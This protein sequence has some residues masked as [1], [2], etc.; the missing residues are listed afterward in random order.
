MKQILSY[1]TVALISISVMALVAVP[2]KATD[3]DPQTPYIQTV[4]PESAK[5]GSIITVVGNCLGKNLASEIFLTRGSSDIKLE[6]T[7]QKASQIVA[8]LP[9]GMEAGRYRL[10]ILST[11]I[12][13]R[14]IEQPVQLIVE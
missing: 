6:I 13:P 5:P 7:S 12:A 9:S 8:K 4:S 10:M 11:G 1:V 3:N 14:F 2:L